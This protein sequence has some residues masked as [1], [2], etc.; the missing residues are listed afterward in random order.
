M[1]N[2]SDLRRGRLACIAL[3]VIA[4]FALPVAVQGADENSAGAGSVDLATA[5]PFVVLGA[6]TVTNTGPSVLNGD[7]GLSPGTELEGFELPAVVNG[8]EHVTDEVAAKAQLDLTAAYNVAAGLPVLPQN[9]LSD[10]N[11]G[12]RKLGPGVYRYNAAALLT[13]ALTLDAE[14][15][16]NAEFIFQIGSQLTTESATRSFW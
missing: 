14:G 5:G 7:L 10:T 12:E 13:G 9:D 16:P 6:T 11:L 8:V 15:D 3:A 1:S 2:R 4:I